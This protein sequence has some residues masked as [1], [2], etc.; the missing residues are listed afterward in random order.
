MYPSAEQWLDKISGNKDEIIITV[1]T[2]SFSGAETLWR[3]GLEGIVRGAMYNAK[4]YQGIETNHHVLLCPVTLYVFG[5]Y[6]KVMYYRVS[7]TLPG[8]GLIE[9]MDSD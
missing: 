2:N 3:Q 1:S 5:R 8:S 6:P 9:K 7:E 4:T